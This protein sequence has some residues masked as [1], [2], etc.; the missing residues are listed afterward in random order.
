MCRLMSKRPVEDEEREGCTSAVATA[1]GGRARRSIRNPKRS[2]SDQQDK[3]SGRAA[4]G[5]GI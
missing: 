4:G 1:G 5:A 3:G 2:K